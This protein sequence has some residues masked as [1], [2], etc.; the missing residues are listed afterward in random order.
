M[1][2]KFDRYVDLLAKRG[3]FNGCDKGSVEY[4][5]RLSK[6]KQ[7]FLTKYHQDKQTE[8]QA[9][10]AAAA[11]SSAGPAT[12]AT[13]TDKYAGLTEAQR[14][15]KAEALKVEGNQKLTTRQY[16]DA[17]ALYSDA[18][19]LNPR[20]AIYYSNRAAAYSHL[21]EHE[22]AITD[23]NAAIKLD[24][25]Y[26]KAYSRLGLAYFSLGKYREAV[27]FGYRKALELEPNNVTAKE[28]L[29][30][31]EAKIA[32][33]EQQEQA[34]RATAGANPAAAAG[35]LPPNPFGA[36]F[37]PEMMRQAMNMFGGAAG[38]AP[39]AAPG[40]AP[41]GLPDMG[42]IASLLNNPQF[43]QMAQNLMTNPAFMNMYVFSC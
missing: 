34:A 20:N 1:R 27:E 17:I 29:D 37:N 10:Q 9:A 43:A 2:G 38:G 35:G 4:N 12:S 6:A 41:G 25:K 24:P 36:A 19:L 11:S 32:E 28:S 21:G 3:Y 23:C 13:P 16:A 22:R 40:A 26:S 8:Q 5:D 7:R 14:A 18:I 33:M 39:G 42:G 31:A 30:S 15:E